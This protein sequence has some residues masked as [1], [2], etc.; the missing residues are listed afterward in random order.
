MANF[1]SPEW[2]FP[3]NRDASMAEEV[4]PEQFFFGGARKSAEDIVAG[5]V[6]TGNTTYLPHSA[7]PCWFLM[8]TK[9]FFVSSYQGA[10]KEGFEVDSQV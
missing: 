7:R 6:P 10:R 1:V 9:Y 5:C 8:T 2:S 4:P 3:L